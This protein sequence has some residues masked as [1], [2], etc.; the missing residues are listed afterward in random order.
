MA[1]IAAT[2]FPEAPDDGKQYARKNGAW[3][4]VTGVA[5][6]AAWGEISGTL[7]SQADLATALGA[8]SDTTHNHDSDYA[9]IAHT[10]P[11]V[12]ISDSTAFGR[13]LVT[14][15][16]A[17]AGRGALS[18]GD[19]A[20][21][22]TGT[23]A[24][25][26]AAGDHNHSGVYQPL[27]SVLTNTTAS[28]TA[29]QESKL[30]G[31]ASGATV[32]ATWGSN[33]SGQ[34]SVVS[35]AEAEA[36]TAT[37]ERIWTAQRVAQAIAALASGGG[38]VIR[39]ARLTAQRTTTA[40]TFA[41]VTDLSISIGA[42]ETW[43]FEAALTCGCNNT[44]GGQFTVTVPSGATLRLMVQGNTSS[45]TAWTGAS[46]TASDGNTV[47]MVT[48]NAQNRLA[49]LSGTVVNGANAGAIQV[50]FRAVTS[51][52]TVTVDAGSYITGRKH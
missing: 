50:R 3:A 14:A 38:A 41:N 22:D 20:Q 32:G 5:G 35:Q 47:N 37:T 1:I 33:V 15:A 13:S 28:F 11:A 27:A 48:A 8:K 7:A 24:G 39:S 12:D 10:H 26:V 17:A 16:D 18:L 49:F 51:G 36:G 34:P 52:Q 2:S 30:S 46:I 9:E 4:E 44:G 19:A 45:A 42:S 21:K 40:N 31:I 29:A 6:T 23:I 25:T 43:S